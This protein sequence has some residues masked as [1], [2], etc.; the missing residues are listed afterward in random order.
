MSTS[1]PTILLVPGSFAAGN[2]YAP[3]VS[4]FRAQGFSA[5]AAQLPSS[6]KRYPL[7]PAT[8]QDDAAH[9]RGIVEQLL[10]EEESRQVVVVAHSYGGTVATE[11]FEGLGT[12]GEGKGG[13]R[14]LV[15]LT[16]TAPRVG[17]TLN[18]ALRQREDLLPKVTVGFTPSP[19]LVLAFCVQSLV[20][21]LW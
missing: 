9:V 2:V 6:Q 21:G 5:L 8:L 14:R 17:E 10:A 4:L 12:H 19:P 13:V 3:L 16:A 20:E 15:F 1:K 7:P 18:T 11:A